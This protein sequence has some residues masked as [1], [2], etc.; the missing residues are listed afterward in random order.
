MSDPTPEYTL[1][2][3]IEKLRPFV[4][5]HALRYARNGL[6]REDLEQEGYLAITKAFARYDPSKGA[7]PHTY[8]CK[9]ALGA[10][11]DL[12]RKTAKR[13]QHEWI[14]TDMEGLENA[15]VDEPP[16]IYSLSNRK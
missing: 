12:A 16:T 1:E 4:Q 2:I 13:N 7:A 8:C 11:Q 10:I 15:V 3:L 14:M 5:F 6:E 9:R